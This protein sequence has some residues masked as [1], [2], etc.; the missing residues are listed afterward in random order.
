MILKFTKMEGAGNDFVFIDDRD[1]QIKLTVEQLQRI[2]DRRFGIGADQVIIVRNSRDADFRM[3]IYNAD[4]SQVEMCG[5]G[6]RCFAKYLKDKK[7]TDKTELTIETL[8][9][10]IATTIIENKTVNVPQ[11]KDT[12]WVKVDM[13]APIL[14]GEDIPVNA[15]GLIIN[16][17]LHLNGGKSFLKMGAGLS[18]DFFIT[19]VSMGNPH[20]VIFV[21]DATDFPIDA[22][23]PEIENH[24]FFP[25]RVNVEFTTVLD[26]D[27]VVMRVWERGSGQTLACGTGACATA[28]ACVLNE[29]T[30]RKVRVHLKGGDLDIEWDEFNDHVYMTGPATSVFEG[31]INL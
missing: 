8:A 4:G 19:C 20:C 16:H 7:I 1:G 23:G 3:D 9:G 17:K 18:H 29:K 15:K 6:V 13:G 28:V 11:A 24:T 10:P 14:E 12:S 26:R 31:E 22:I 5:N 21:E 25:N 2:C 27:N 30:N